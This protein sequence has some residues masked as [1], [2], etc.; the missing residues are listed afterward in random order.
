MAGGEDPDGFFGERVA[1]RYD[2]DSAAISTA[3]ATAPIVD[4]L[5]ALAG[6]GP[7]LELGVGTGRIALPLAERGVAVHGI[8]LSRA[9]AGRL[10]AKPGGDKVPVTIGDF[11]T[12]RAPGAFPLAYL[13]FNTIENLTTQEAQVAC[14]INVAR[15]LAPGG[16][17][18]IEVEVPAIR[19]LPPGQLLH[20]SI[21]TKRHW[22][23]DEFDLVRQRGIS[24]HFTFRDGKVRHSPF[25]YRY[26]WP[27]ELDLMARIA[28]MELEAR[29]GG[30]AGEPF[31]SDSAKHVSVWR[32][33][34]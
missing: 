6:A 29:H 19:S 15:H 10:A 27:S 18:V 1:S 32:K 2:E 9:M 12:V 11:A 28:A 34:K 31:T 30:W 16:R 33:V 21:A 3:E 25:P 20:P 24:H 17:F 5:A 7:A 8:E 13:V 22:C 23:I 4:F 26:V 14:F